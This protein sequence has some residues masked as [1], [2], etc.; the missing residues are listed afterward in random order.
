M[1]V[2]KLAPIKRNPLLHQ[3]VQESIKSFILDNNLSAGDPLP[4]EGELARQLGVSRNSVREAV[5]ALETTGILEVRRGSGVYVASFSFEPILNNLPYGLIND[6]RDI[7]E[8]LEIR[9][10]LELALLEK[11]IEHQTD[12][13][14][15]QLRRV[16][17][18]MRIEAE[19]GESLS[20]EDRSFHR[21]L[22]QNLDNRALL[23]LIDVFW[24]TF[25]QA[26]QHTNLRDRDPLSTYQ[27]HEAIYEAF[28]QRDLTQ[29]R[30]MLDQHYNGIRARITELARE[31][32]R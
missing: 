13:Q 2:A 12:G 28:V 10:V 6:V 14:V 18:A 29:T 8:L 20:A 26:A 22:F 4:A 24:L 32:D 1:I 25:H 19:S 3:S 16:L 17:D 9:S 23:K 5:K 7:A 31:E 21:L 27:D 11:A 15:E 30:A